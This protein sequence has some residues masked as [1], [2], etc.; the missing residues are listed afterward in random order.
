MSQQ[1]G[2][3]I[4]QD[5]G[6]DWAQDIIAKD[7]RRCVREDCK[8]VERFVN[9][10]WIDVTVRQRPRKQPSVVQPSLF[11]PDR[12]FPDKAEERRAEQAYR[13]MLGR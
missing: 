9:E 10:V 2:N 4:C 6:H 3:R 12:L 1:Q 11:A 8:T 7:Y 5:V 13:F